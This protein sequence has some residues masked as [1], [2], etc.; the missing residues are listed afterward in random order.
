M[1]ITDDCRQHHAHAAAGTIC[2]KYGLQAA[3]AA[4][5]AKGGG[6][7]YTQQGKK[8]QGTVVRVC[9][10]AVAL[11][12]VVQAI[13]QRIVCMAGVQWPRTVCLDMWQTQHLQNYLSAASVY[14]L[15]VSECLAMTKDTM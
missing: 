13:T 11:G 15:H 8:Q 5:T 6:G 7:S 14:D 1:F 3:A 4:A 10:A 9:A 12:R 2:Q